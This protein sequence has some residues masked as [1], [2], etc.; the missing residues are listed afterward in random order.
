MRV[1]A[2]ATLAAALALGACGFEPLYAKREGMVD[3][4]EQ[5]AKVRIGEIRD[6]ASSTLNGFRGY[7]VEND[8]SRQILRNY[9]LDDLQPR[10]G[11][12]RGEYILSLSVIEPRTDV[13]IDRSDTT[14]RYGYSVVAQFVLR[15]NAG[16]NM[17]RG[18]AVSST[19][20]AVSQSEFATISSQKDARDRAMQEISQDIRNQLAAFFHSAAKAP[21]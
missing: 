2:M 12:A 9:L 15:D 1:L 4:P 6:P 5:L 21:Q 11:A 14:L 19:S 18:S 8:R 13:A 17:F 7:P 3:V 16:R 10:G 20:F